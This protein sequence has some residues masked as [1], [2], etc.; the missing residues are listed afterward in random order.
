MVHGGLGYAFFRSAFLDVVGQ[1]RPIYLFQAPGL[2]GRTPPLE[3]L[4][5]MV[6]LYLRTMHE[7]QPKGPYYIA[8]MCGGSFIALEMCRRLSETGETVGRLIL[9]DPPA[10]PPAIKI[11]RLRTS[12]PSS[13]LT[14]ALGFLG[15]GIEFA[16][17]KL[18]DYGLALRARAKKQRLREDLQ[19]RRA[20]LM[21][22]VA[23]E[24]RSYAPETMLKVAETLRQAL[25][26]HVPLPYPG[27][28][29]MLVAADREANTLGQSSFWRTLVGSIEHEVGG[30]NHEELFTDRLIDTA[31]F[32]RNALEK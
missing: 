3:R 19:I 12:R 32:V 7:I 2:D 28:A 26:G 31:N 8:A 24:E 14:R 9:L 1:D 30:A 13:L 25:D 22:I 15:V 11:Q 6:A 5:D 4:N 10:V 27:H 21:D 18:D 23:P 20:E 29:T 17:P 16:R